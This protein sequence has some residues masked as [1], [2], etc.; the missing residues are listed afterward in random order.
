VLQCVAV[1]CSVLQCVAQ[2]AAYPPCSSFSSTCSCPVIECLVIASFP[3]SLA[4]T[5]TVEILNCSVRTF[6][7][8]L[9]SST[10]SPPPPVPDCLLV[11]N[12][13]SLPDDMLLKLLLFCDS[14]RREHGIARNDG[15]D[16]RKLREKNEGGGGEAGRGEGGRG[17]TETERGSERVSGG[18][19]VCS[20]RGIQS[21]FVHVYLYLYVRTCISMHVYVYVYVYAH[22]CVCMQLC[23]YV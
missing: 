20:A 10:V 23:V 6:C 18:R 7:A 21:I 13:E 11:P 5:Y 19:R 9:L 12:N 4:H 2:R 22:I 1:C 3:V 17:E 16:G 15:R 8:S 14:K